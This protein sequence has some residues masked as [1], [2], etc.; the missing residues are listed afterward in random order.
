MGISVRTGLNTGE[1]ELREGDVSGVAVHVAARV[2]A[3][4]QAGE[5]LVSRVVKDLLPGAGLKF[6]ERGAQEFKGL[7]GNWDLFTVSS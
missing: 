4:A 2:M 1:I 3:K 7:P 5:V 6:F